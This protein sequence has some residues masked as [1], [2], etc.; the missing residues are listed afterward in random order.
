MQSTMEYIGSWYNWMTTPAED[1]GSEDGGSPQASPQTSP[2]VSHGHRQVQVEQDVDLKIVATNAAKGTVRGMMAAGEYL[3]KTTRPVERQIRPYAQT[4]AKTLAQ[5]FPT[6]RDTQRQRP[7]SH[8]DELLR[9]LHKLERQV[10]TERA[11]A[12]FKSEF[13]RQYAE[14]SHSM[15]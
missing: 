8:E 2:K 12:F 6:R 9:E 10:G 14:F 7:L 13:V 15:R 1:S 11:L 4:A 5:L 3:E